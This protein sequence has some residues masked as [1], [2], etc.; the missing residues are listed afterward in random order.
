MV[1]WLNRRVAQYPHELSLV[2]WCIHSGDWAALKIFTFDIGHCY[3]K[4]HDCAKVTGNPSNKIVLRS[5]LFTD[6]GSLAIYIYPYNDP[7]FYPNIFVFIFYFIH[8]V[9]RYKLWSVIYLSKPDHFKCSFSVYHF[10]IQVILSRPPWFY[11]EFLFV[12]LNGTMICSSIR[13]YFC[14][15]ESIV[16]VDY[17]VL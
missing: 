1:H 5:W 11:L 9:W 16:P 2:V 15:V 14:S 12:Q 4:I 8:Q 13:S 6:K 7:F 17:S 3:G 10:F